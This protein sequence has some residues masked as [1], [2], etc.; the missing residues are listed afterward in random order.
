MIC[1]LKARMPNLVRLFSSFHATGTNWRPDL[2]LNW[3]ACEA[4][5]NRSC[6]IWSASKVPRFVKKSVALSQSNLAGWFLKILLRGLWE[7]EVGI[8]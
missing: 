4:P 7:C 6:N 2:S 5:L 1:S 8:Q 3:Q